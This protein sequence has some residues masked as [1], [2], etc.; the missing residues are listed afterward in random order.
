[1]ARMAALHGNKARQGRTGAS[2]R[3]PGEAE[4]AEVPARQ[5]RAACPTGAVTVR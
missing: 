3:L 5:S 1:M 4:A 2:A